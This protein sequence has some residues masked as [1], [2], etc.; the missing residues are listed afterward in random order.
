VTLK[1]RVHGVLHH[2]G[3]DLVRFD[4]RK[5][6]ERKRAEL[7]ESLSTDLVIDVG[8]NV[9]QY[10][11]EIR[12]NGFCGTI[13]AFEPLGRPFQEIA[14]LAERDS[15]LTV[16]RLA[17]GSDEAEAIIH[18]AA[19]SWSSS[20]LAMKQT[21]LSAAP[22]SVYV[23]EERIEIRPLDSLDLIHPDDIAWL[24]IDTQGSERSVLAGARRSLSRAVAV[25]IEL[26]YV[27]LYEDQ[28]LAWEIHNTLSNLGFDLVAFGTPFS[29]RGTSA[30]L[31][32]DAIFLRT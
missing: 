28:A 15:K 16:H 21:H 5:F 19:N 10:V 24:K 26:T 2:L 31:Q 4:G 7:M 29:D 20:L 12:A 11:R 32:V 17:L 13:I 30:L 9:G 6:P 27:A 8:A 22:D 25:E 1:G 14:E 23:G 3:F 18:V